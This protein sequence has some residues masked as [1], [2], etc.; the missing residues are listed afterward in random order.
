ME[1]IRIT[2]LLSSNPLTFLREKVI[3][4]MKRTTRKPEDL[5]SVYDIMGKINAK[6]ILEEMNDEE[7]VTWI[8]WKRNRDLVNLEIDQERN[9]HVSDEAL[10]FSWMKWKKNLEVVKSQKNLALKIKQESLNLVIEVAA[11]ASLNFF[12]QVLLVLPDLIL[13]SFKS[14]P[15]KSSYLELMNWKYL[16]ILSSFATMANSYS[17]IQILQKDTICRTVIFG[18]FVY[19]TNPEGHFDVWNAISLYYG[20]VLILLFFNIIFNR[21]SPSFSGRYIISLLLNSMTSFYSYNYYN[22]FDSRNESAINQLF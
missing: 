12:I 2:R 19:F 13:A 11:E 7:F 4:N 8:K 6:E 22:F 21:C 14:Y 5:F 1:K 10:L 15:S 18:C 3:K 16:S 17:I 9:D 20:H